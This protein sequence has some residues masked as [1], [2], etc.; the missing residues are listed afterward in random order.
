MK[1]SCSD[2]YH[3]ML[4]CRMVEFKGESESMMRSLK[5]NASRFWVKRGPKTCSD[6]FPL[7]QGAEHEVVGE[8]EE[9]GEEDAREG[10]G[11]G[12]AQKS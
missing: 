8:G 4:T 9:E 12:G 5:K 1:T 6:Q 10:Q 7:V 3:L 2:Y 11:Q